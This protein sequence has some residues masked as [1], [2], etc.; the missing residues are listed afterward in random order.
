MTIALITAAGIGSRMH[1]EIP[2]QFLCVNNKPIIFYTLETFQNHPSV[3]SIVLVTLDS[4]RPLVESYARQYKI[5]KL[6]QIVSGGSTGQES[7]HNGLMAMSDIAKKDEFIII[8][9]GNR[10]LVS[11][12]IISDALSVAEKYG[13]AVAAIPCV[14]VVFE[15]EKLSPSKTALDR[16]KLLRTQTP[17]IY[18]FADL[19]QA[20]KEAQERKI[21]N[22]AATCVLMQQL[23]KET[24][25]SIGSVENFKIT[26]RKD[27]E[28]FEALIF[29]RKRT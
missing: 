14:E 2:K 29:S 15:S 27:L 17:H 7:I 16:T 28:I 12:E 1:L 25:F 10:P 6:K 20:H 11:S 18:K 8:H 5:T 13:S 19:I 26:E 4:W 22:T 3:D 9:D 24:Y 21:F 23:G